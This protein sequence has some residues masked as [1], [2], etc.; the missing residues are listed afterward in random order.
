MRKTLIL[1][2][3]LLA[4]IYFLAGSVVQGQ[5]TFQQIYPCTHDQSS[6][7]VIETSDGGYLI[8]GM[9]ETTIPGDTDIIVLKTDYLGD[10]MWVR[11]FGGSQPDFPYSIVP[12]SDNNFF[13]AGYTGSYGSGGNDAWLLKIDPMGNLLWS[14]T[15]G[16]TGNDE[17][18]EIIATSDGNYMMVGRSNSS[19][20]WYYD[21][22]LLKINLAG[23]VL[24]SKYYGGAQYE[25]TRSVK[26]CPDGGYVLTGQTMSYGQGAGDIYLIRTNSTGD[27]LWTRT[28]GGTGIDDGNFIVCNSDT[29]FVIVAE[30]ESYGAGMMDVQVLKT[31]KNGTVVWNKFYGGNDKDVSKTIYP[32]T[33]GGYIVG[34]ISRSFGWVD[35]DMWLLKLDAYGDTT[36]TRHY[37][38]WDHEHC[39]HARQ[40]S[41]GGY[42]A[43]GHTKSYGPNPRIMFLKLNSNGLPGPTAI[44]ELSEN[45][46]LKV[47]PNPSNGVVQVEM[48]GVPRA[49]S[50]KICNAIGEVIASGNFGDM[51]SH[52]KSIDLT[53]KNPGIYMLCI[54]SEGELRI[55]KF[56]LN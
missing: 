7:D 8:A 41:D 20:A 3:S 29:S 52:T 35:P 49:S 43:V 24:M 56:V 39:H 21:G 34:A 25:T 45:N 53:G 26:E 28:Y 27:T 42:M 14:N 18:K 55:R 23:T 48:N 38:S 46:L 5:I 50:Y 17:V 36:W 54:L 1:R 22:W 12:T 9:T 10:T 2:L 13:I 4:L 30:T 37:G 47:Y 19:G 51:N 44:D 32:T 31:D 33:D 16:G 11:I 15:Y 40:T 6:R